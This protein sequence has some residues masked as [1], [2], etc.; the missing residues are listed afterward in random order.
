LH[1]V[2]GVS[3]GL[4]LASAKAFAQSGASLF[5]SARSASVLQKIHEELETTYQVPVASAVIDVSDE[6]T[7]IAGV[8]ACVK[9]FGRIDVVISNGES[10]P[11]HF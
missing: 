6:K 3:K 5:L 9:A 11:S 10:T 8:E 1:L 4:G 2:T 7:I